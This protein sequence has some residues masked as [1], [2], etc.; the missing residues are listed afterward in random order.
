MSEKWVEENQYE[1]Y[2]F[3]LG[4]MGVVRHVD[5]AWEFFKSILEVFLGE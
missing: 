3:L 5:E 4:V 2:A 1:K